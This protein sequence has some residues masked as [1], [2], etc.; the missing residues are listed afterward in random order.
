MEHRIRDRGLALENE[1]FDDRQPGIEGGAYENLPFNNEAPRRAPRLLLGEKLAQSADRGA[2]E[3]DGWL[4]QPS[5]PFAW[6]T[7]RPKASMS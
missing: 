6:A 4:V 1:L 2:R 7:R 3:P 5:A